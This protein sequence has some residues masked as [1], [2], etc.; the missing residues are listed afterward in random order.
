V[1][2]ERPEDERVA[3]DVDTLGDA[4]VEFRTLLGLTDWRGVDNVGL[5]FGDAA[6]FDPAHGLGDAHDAALTLAWGVVRRMETVNTRFAD[7]LTEAVEWYGMADQH[8]GAA[9]RTAVEA[10][11]PNPDDHG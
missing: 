8:S 7:G 3:V 10:M 6:A 5:A 9:V 1:G 2:V 4:A 11:R